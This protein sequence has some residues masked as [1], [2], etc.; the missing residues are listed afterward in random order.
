MI[1]DS[2]ALLAIALDEPEREA[3]VARINAAEVVAVA[4]PTLVEAGIVLSARTGEDAGELLA[5]LVAA[6]DAVVIEFGAGH[7]QEAVSAWWRFGRSRHPAA[8]NLGDCLAYATAKLA[9][10]P[11]LAKGNDFPQTD[12]ALA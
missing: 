12:I 2:S 10:E 8:L 5:E 1:L 9:N 7:W 11:L 6:S 4:A 3:F